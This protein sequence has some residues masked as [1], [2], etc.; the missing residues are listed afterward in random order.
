M[1][2]VQSSFRKKLT[3]DVG[4][5]V[6]HFDRNPSWRF[7]GPR[8]H[9]NKNRGSPRAWSKNPCVITQ[10]EH[11]RL[12][13]DPLRDASP[14][15]GDGARGGPAGLA[16]R[17]CGCILLQGYGITGVAPDP[18]TAEGTGRFFDRAAPTGWTSDWRV[19]GLCRTSSWTCR[20]GVQ[21]T[22]APGRMGTVRLLSR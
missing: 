1:L 22:A 14:L 6:Q 17:A 8:N 2:T 4:R 3:V 9:W 11:T 15:A 21:R 19:R 5:V 16:T 12:D 18:V 20:T 7:A 10:P 13:L